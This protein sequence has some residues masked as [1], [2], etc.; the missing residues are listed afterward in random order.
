M[1]VKSDVYGF[2]VVLL[3]MLTGLQ[4]YDTNRASGEHNLVQWTRPS[5]SDKKKLKKK[6]DPRLREH[7]PL[8]GA[9]QAA[10]LILKCLESDPK[11]RPSMEEVLE[12]LMKISAIKMT[13]KET[14]ASAK[15]GANR[16]QEVTNANHRRPPIHHDSHH[17]NRSP[18]HQR[19]GAIGS[20]V[21]AYRH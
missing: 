9:F 16:R 7:Y 10:Q 12:E 4:A 3:E 15:H 5:M 19:H 17:G 21:G 2:G 8:E 13:A 11:N 6:M 1:Y 20:G 14:K 18:I